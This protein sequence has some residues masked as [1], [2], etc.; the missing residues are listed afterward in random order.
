[1]N[2]ITVSA[3]QCTAQGT[4]VQQPRVTLQLN[5]SLIAAYRRNDVL[6][7]GTSIIKLGDNFY[8]NIRKER[9]QTQLPTGRI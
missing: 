2:F 9:Q 7:Q 8:T 4:T 5:E 3:D 6:L 1:M